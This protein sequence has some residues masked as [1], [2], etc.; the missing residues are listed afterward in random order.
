M[1]REFISNVALDLR[2]R[3][4]AVH[5]HD[6][7]VDERRAFARVRRR[8]TI[9]PDENYVALYETSQEGHFFPAPSHHRRCF[10]R[11]IARFIRGRSSRHAR[12]ESKP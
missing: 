4:A 1:Q 7:N 9:L 12:D 8:G 6:R 5:R 10:Y 3:V 11:R 2:G